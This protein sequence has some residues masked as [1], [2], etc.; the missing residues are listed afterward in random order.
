MTGRSM[1]DGVGLYGGESRPS[2]VITFSAGPEENFFKEV[3]N[4]IASESRENLASAGWR[5][6]ATEEGL[7]DLPN[8]TKRRRICASCWSKARDGGGAKFQNFKCNVCTSGRLLVH[9]KVCVALF[10][11]H[12]RM[13]NPWNGVLAEEVALEPLVG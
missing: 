2:G 10:V 11:S 13:R 4:C 6:S 3:S 5:G 12:M 7:F 9:E 8:A 1:Q